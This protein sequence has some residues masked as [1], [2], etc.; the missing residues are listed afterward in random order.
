MYVWQILSFDFP[1]NSWEWE[2][3]RLY[4][5]LISSSN[6]IYGKI[7]VLELFLKI[8]SFWEILSSIRFKDFFNCNITRKSRRIMKIFCMFLETTMETT[9]LLCCFSW[10]WSSMPWHARSADKEQITN[11]SVLIWGIVLI[12]LIR[13]GSYGNSLIHLEKMAVVR[14]VWVVSN[15]SEVAYEQHLKNKLIYCLEV[16]AC[17][18]AF[19]ETTNWSGQACLVMPKVHVND[20]WAIYLK[21]DA[22]HDF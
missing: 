2:N 17:S 8:L 3:E 14:Y 15:C 10:V 6:T 13:L 19:M 1:E 5:Y 12:F 22:F 11:I 20:R 9:N 18:L 4:F 16:F 7:L 21:T